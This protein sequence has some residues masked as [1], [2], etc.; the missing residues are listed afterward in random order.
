VPA[1]NALPH[2]QP[3]RLGPL[4]GVL[5]YM[6]RP[7]QDELRVDEPPP[8]GRKGPVLPKR[9]S[10]AVKPGRGSSA[11]RAVSIETGIPS[12]VPAHDR[13]DRSTPQAWYSHG[14][15]KTPPLTPVLSGAELPDPRVSLRG[16]LYESGL[17]GVKGVGRA[18]LSFRMSASS[19]RLGARGP[20]GGSS[21]DS[22][23]EIP[24]AWETP[25]GPS[26]RNPTDWRFV[27][28]PASLC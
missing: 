24:C 16:R 26:S 13:R 6:A 22:S 10:E 28:S 7:A 2:D 25:T 5:G 20:R 23:I 14:A 8:E 15:L 9:E 18:S 21:A 27:P 1:G 4:P 3:I 19:P 17:A 11:V 12:S